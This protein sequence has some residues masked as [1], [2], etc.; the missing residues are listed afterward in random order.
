MKL[1][2]RR[3][4]VNNELETLMSSLH[5]FKLQCADHP[6]LEI[7]F[8]IGDYLQYQ[9]NRNCI[10]VYQLTTL[11]KLLND[12]VDILG[13]CERI[14]KTPMPFELVAGLGWWT[15]PI[16]AFITL[17][18]LGIEEIGAEIEE[19]FGHDPNDLPLDLICATMVRNV[20]DL[21]RSAPGNRTFIDDLRNAKTK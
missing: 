16:L 7:T 12:M 13:G 19:P 2:L 10:D 4:A 18:L 8:W 1:H 14:L 5:Y 11:Q 9:F 21:I 15:G 17:V 3:E 6:A 20:E